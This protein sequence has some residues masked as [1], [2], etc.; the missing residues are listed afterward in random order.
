MTDTDRETLKSTA[1]AYLREQLGA[2]APAELN[3]ESA[4]DESPLE[5][6]GPTAL[7]SFH[8]APQNEHCGDEAMRHYVAVGQTSPNYLPAYELAP[9]DA[10]S[11]HIGTVFMLEVGIS[12][13]PADSAPPGAAESVAGFVAR[14]APQTRIDEIEQLAVFRAE[15]VYFGVFR[16]RIDDRP[17]L[18]VGALP[19]DRGN[20]S[21]TPGFYER[22]DLPPQVALRLHLGKL[23]RNEAQ[24]GS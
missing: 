23:I 12:I 14:E 13:A 3:F 4:F 10:Y 24:S 20:Q 9:D 1:L 2:R 22:T 5:T 11:L 17:T 16:A 8:L 7:F 15:D 18:C 6:E 21:A 19:F